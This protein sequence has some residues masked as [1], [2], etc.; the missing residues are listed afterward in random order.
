M[1]RVVIAAS[2]T[3]RP[4]RWVYE[5]VLA[6]HALAV[7]DQVIEMS[8]T[9][10]AIGTASHPATQLSPVGVEHAILER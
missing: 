8:N 3:M 6:D 1:R 7:A 4:S 10:G 2:E 5:I 9:C